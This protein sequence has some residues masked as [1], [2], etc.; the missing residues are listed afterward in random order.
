MI[1]DN[2]PTIREH[3][4]KYVMIKKKVFIYKTP[5]RHSLLDLI[6]RRFLWGTYYVVTGPPRAKAKHNKR[7][8]NIGNSNANIPNISVLE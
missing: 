3:G 2:V 6:L 5:P 7:N 1:S 8:T 4:G